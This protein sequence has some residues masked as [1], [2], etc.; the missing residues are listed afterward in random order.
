MMAPRFVEAKNFARRPMCASSDDALRPVERYEAYVP[1]P[2]A[3]GARAGLAPGDRE[4][5]LLQRRALRE[6]LRRDEGA[7]ERREPPLPWRAAA[8]RDSSEARRASSAAFRGDEASL[9]A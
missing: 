2:G 8:T 9:A 3:A 4:D 5:R 7:R 1:S 6:R